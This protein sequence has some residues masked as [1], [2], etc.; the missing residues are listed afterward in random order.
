MS[1][2]RIAAWVAVLLAACAGPGLAVVVSSASAFSNIT[3]GQ[4]QTEAGPNIFLPSTPPCT[5]TLVSHAK[6]SGY[7]APARGTYDPSVCPGPWSKVVLTL[8]ASVGG[9]QFDRLVD[10]RLGNAVFLH[11]STSEPASLDGS[12]T[13]WTV[14]RDVTQYGSLLSASQP[15]A[16]YLDNVTNSTYTGVY[17]VTV[18]LTF[19]RGQSGRSAPDEPDVVAPVTQSDSADSNDG[20][21]FTLSDS[22]PPSS[23]MQGGEVTLPRNLD[24]LEAELF[25]S[26]GGPCEEFWW[27][28][29][30][31]CPG[32]PYREVDIYIDGRLAGAAPV[33]P[34]AFTG[35]DGP[36]F[37]EPIPSP[38]AWDL[39]PYDV[40]LTPFIG[41]LSD[42]QPHAVQLA[43]ADAAYGDDSPGSDYWKVAANLLGWT[44]PGASV[45]GG[46][47]TAASNQTAPSENISDPTGQAV[48]YTDDATHSLRFAGTVD[49]SSGVRSVTVE[50]SMSETATQASIGSVNGNWSWD[51]QTT[52][53]EPDG[54][55]LTSSDDHTY[56]AVFDAAA[57]FNFTDDDNASDTVNGRSTYSN[58]STESMSTTNVL[59]DPLEVAEQECYSRSD[60]LGESYTDNIQALGGVVVGSGPDEPCLTAGQLGE[61][62]P[63]PAAHRAR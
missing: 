51:S 63:V 50:E 8:S 60:S 2:R 57:S 49:T 4:T 36:T 17:D 52:T 12:D 37:W 27:T 28:D 22:S 31:N 15:V 16:V 34:S 13:Y 33:Y 26:G 5:E 44:D 62:G 59:L 18:S 45:T 39:V 46:A 9:V 32:T 24:R 35:F 58:A 21:M 47:L 48:P 25:A 53:V 14:Q 55:K 38:R 23:E 54:T 42:G 10:V 29:P 41:E 7:Y 30:G 61:L 19:Y 56:S 3:G 1:G 6:F 43:I 40:D 20:P 11:G